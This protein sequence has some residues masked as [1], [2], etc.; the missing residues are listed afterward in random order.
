MFQITFALKTGMQATPLR[1]PLV[2]FHHYQQFAVLGTFFLIFQQSWQYNPDVLLKD[3][4]VRVQCYSKILFES[5]S[6]HF[7]P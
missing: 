1:G 7:P 6:F 4:R 3:W 5:I 2:Y